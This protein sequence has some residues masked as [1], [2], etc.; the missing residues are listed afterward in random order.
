[1]KISWPQG[2]GT[3]LQEENDKESHPVRC[4]ECKQVVI[5]QEF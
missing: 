2:C 3:V 4:D 1:M 5:H